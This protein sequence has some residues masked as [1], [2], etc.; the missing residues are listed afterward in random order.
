MNR[1]EKREF[2]WRLF[3][4]TIIKMEEIWKDIEGYEGLYQVSNLGRVKSLKKK[5]SKEDRIRKLRL[6]KDGYLVVSLWKYGKPKTMKVHR[7]IAISFIENIENKSF[8]NHLDGIKNNNSI[9]NLEWVTA[10]ENTKHAHYTG[11]MNK[12]LVIDLVTNKIYNS[13]AEASKFY[14][15]DASGLSKMLRGIN[16]N[17]TNLQ[18][19]KPTKQ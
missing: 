1:R 14:S 18:Y 10:S 7:L 9:E 8:V 4:L 5:Y 19:Y 15:I 16:T 11:L 3:I 13:T 2:I 6:D 12:K 17:R